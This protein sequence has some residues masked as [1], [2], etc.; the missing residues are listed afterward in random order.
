[1]PLYLS[2]DDMGLKQNLL[3]GIFAYGFETPSPIQ[4]RAIVSAQA[5]RD[6]YVQAKA[7][8][9]KTGTF[10]IAALQRMDETRRELQVL[11][12]SPTR[13][14]AAQTSRVVT[15]LGDYM[16]VGVQTLTGGT[17]TRDDMQALRSGAVQVACGTPGRVMHMLDKGSLRTRAISMVIVDE[18]DAMLSEGFVDQVS[19]IFAQLPDS[20]QVLLVSATMPPALYEMT[21]KVMRHPVRLIIPDEEVNLANIRQHVVHVQSQADKLPTIESLYEHISVAQCIIFTNTQ[22]LAHSLAAQL[23]Q[24]EHSVSVLTG[25]MPQEERSEVLS[26]F[27]R[28]D[29]R[30]LV[31]TNVLARGIDVQQVRL[32]IN[33]DLPA[34]PESYVHRI[35]RCGRW[36]RRGMAISLVTR[37]EMPLI[38]NIERHWRCAITPLPADFGKEV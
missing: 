30:L 32:V 20:V 16:G 34:D 27:R 1:M 38:E 28:G 21:R 24:R 7:G 14:L 26:A 33:Y 13:E 5:G 31:A 37:A 12:L 9:G 8:T 22:R 29:T 35:G 25:E 18:A 36:G 10:A 17:S 6:M 19:G 11:I 3:R 23:R 4:Q 2:F 15:C